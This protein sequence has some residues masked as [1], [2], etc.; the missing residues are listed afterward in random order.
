MSP[1][2]GDIGRV[3]GLAVEGGGYQAVVALVAIGEEVVAGGVRVVAAQ[4][5]AVLGALDLHVP[6]VE[7]HVEPV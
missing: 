1:D 3:E 2:P 6:I 5:P 7:V 4:C